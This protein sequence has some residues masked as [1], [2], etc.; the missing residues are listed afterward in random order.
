MGLRVHQGSNIEARGSGMIMILQ[1]KGYETFG[2]MLKAANSV[3][4]E[5]E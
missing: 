5:F 1:R 3:P 2:P 4:A